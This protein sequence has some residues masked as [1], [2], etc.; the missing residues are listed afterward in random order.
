MVLAKPKVKFAG[1]V[2]GKDGIK[3]DSEKI[4]AVNKFPTHATRQDLKSFMVLIN[5]FRQ[6]NQAVTKS[7]YLLKPLLS[8]KSQ[9]IWLPDHQKAFE[10]LKE[11]L[12][13]SPSLAHFDPKY[14]T[15]IETDASR[16]KG[17]GYVLL[18]RQDLEW[19]L[20]A[21]GLRYLRDV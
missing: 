18:Q 10:E 13:K 9:Y 7:S 4:E 2:V 6:F 11:D 15:R 16:K 12:S 21:A 1:Y 19:K 5:Q 3:L 14:E 8:P 17:F 20:V